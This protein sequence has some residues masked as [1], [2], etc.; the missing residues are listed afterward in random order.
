MPVGITRASRAAQP[1]SPR[2]IIAWVRTKVPE[3]AREAFIA[4]GF[5]VEE[6]TLAELRNPAKISGFAA[7][8]FSQNPK[9]QRQIVTDLSEVC[10]A[11]LNYD[12]LVVAIPM[13][14]ILEHNETSNIVK[15]LLREKIF[16]ANLPA[17]AKGHPD[18]NREGDPPLPNVLLFQGSNWNAL[19]NI[20]SQNPPGPPPN[21]DLDI[22]RP[23]AF[24]RRGNKVKSPHWQDDYEVLVRRAFH[25]CDRVQLTPMPGGNSEVSVYKAYP[26]IS[27]TD[28]LSLPMPHFVKIG[29]R[30]AIFEE[31]NNYRDGVEP[32][33]PFHLGPHLNY[34]R[35]CLGEQSGILV[36]DYVE[37]SE[38]L[39]DCAREG[40]ASAPLGC[41]FDRALH[42]WHR[43]GEKLEKSIA[44]LLGGFFYHRKI[45][46]QRADRARELGATKSIGELRG[47]FE[48]C[49]EKKI[50]VGPTHG[51][52]HAGNVRVRA[53][54]AI[55]IDFLAHRS[56]PLL[57]DFAALETSLL[58][59]GFEEDSLREGWDPKEWL[60]SVMSLY[61]GTPLL[62]NP[63]HS[64]PKHEVSWFHECIRFI[65][66]YAGRV[67]LCSNQ[68]AGALAV[69]L[70]IKAS[71][72][73]KAPDPRNSRLA[74]AFVIA[75]KILSCTFGKV[76][77]PATTA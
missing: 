7:V 69:A 68:Y 35:C 73:P 29:P 2:T 49:N 43:S 11:I 10:R 53:N 59:D 33:V 71:K 27:N 47:L 72:E 39:I 65:R 54:D 4:R 9:K 3:E 60:N 44:E 57:C 58:V 21:K 23:P 74:G 56:R 30:S 45:S 13:D 14:Q 40:R 6:V 50:L 32:Y 17:H 34:D 12:C 20:I 77:Q 66:L 15:Y 8:I 26:E 48:L 38:S 76:A 46:D 62:M 24:D 63:P 31:Y 61:D 55:L 42:G 75:E 64:N 28:P 36:G 37:G 5:A 67:E 18:W 1:V 52:L 22:A 70:V 25:D 16:T 51:D 19:A 41:L